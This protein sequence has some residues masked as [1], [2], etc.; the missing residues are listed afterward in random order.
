MENEITSEINFLD[1]TIS[2]AYD[3]LQF[4]I[5][6]KPTANNVLIHSN[7]CHPAEHNMSGKN[8]LINRLVAY[9]INDHNRN[10]KI[11]TA[12]HISKVNNY[13]H[14]NLHE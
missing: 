8:Y 14:L 11:F 6:R 3:C 5:Y 7:S 2:R 1:T 10:I 4:R 12:E 9:P 13:H